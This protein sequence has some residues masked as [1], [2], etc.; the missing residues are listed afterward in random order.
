MWAN[1]VALAKQIALEMFKLEHPEERQSYT[2]TRAPA[3][4]PTP[5]SKFKAG[6][7]DRFRALPEPLS[8]QEQIAA[9]NVICMRALGKSVP[10]PKPP[11]RPS[12][13]AWFWR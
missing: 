2:P 4:K 6:T 7:Q 13:L 10:M 8:L 9:G 1:D 5:Q 3:P 11:R 12:W